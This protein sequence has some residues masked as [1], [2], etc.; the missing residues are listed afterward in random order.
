MERQSAASEID[1]ATR[2]KL[3]ERG[4]LRPAVSG[5]SK[6]EERTQAY[7]VTREGIEIPFPN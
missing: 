3:I 1:E 4:V 7:F 6:K 2:L 5:E